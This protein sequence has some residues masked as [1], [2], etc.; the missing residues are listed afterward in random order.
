MFPKEKK[1]E[2]KLIALSFLASLISN[3]GRRA[4]FKVYLDWANTK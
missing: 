1:Y 4:Y 3:D 2:F